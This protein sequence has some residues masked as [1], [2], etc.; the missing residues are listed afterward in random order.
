M[1]KPSG[2]GQAGPDRQPWQQ[3]RVELGKRSY[4]IV[5]GERLL[6]KA[7]QHIAAVLK[8]RNVIII[9]DE[10][11][12][13]LYLHRLTN[14][15]EEE[16]IR[17]RSIIVKPGEGTKSLSVFA[18]VMESL[19]ALK[20]E[21]KTTL[22]ALGGGVV[23]DLTGFAASVL[24]RGVEFIQI[25]T[26][27]LSQVDSSVGGKTGINSS[28]GK[29]LIGSFHQPLL[30]L[31]DVTTLTTLPKR[32]LL[33]GYAE[34]VKYGLINDPAFFGWLEENGLAMLAGDMD[35]MTQAI[36]RSCAAKAAIVA[37]DEKENDVR[38]LLNLGHT[39]GHALEAETGYGDALL[40][41]E[42][43]AIGM[44]LAFQASVAMGLCP[45]ADLQR[46]LAHFQAA[47][48]PQAPR[49]VRTG[50]DI[51]RLMEHFSRDK[52]AADG[53]L[54][55]ILAGGI[56]KAFITQEVNRE[57]IRDTLAQACAA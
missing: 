24:L 34:M 38:A 26:T 13:R 22:I 2:A 44:V 39:F 23:G 47:G 14:A 40:H 45:Q 32:E 20:P 52:K 35:L 3:L 57:V 56:G 16:K 42:A 21:R 28:Y 18:E 46:L 43:V 5:V 19:L 37:A 41:G 29:N 31:A 11:V 7:G 30:V 48:L 9:S 1:L 49:Q 33:A 12:A 6:A 25:P 54:T 51:D 55:F 15:L 17:S 10:T 4:D 36:V 53:K 27:L 8:N 50:W